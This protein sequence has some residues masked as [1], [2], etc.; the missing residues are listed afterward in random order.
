MRYFELGDV[1]LQSGQVLRAGRL[2]YAAFGRLNAARDNAVLFPTFYTGTHRDNAPLV[3]RG[4]ALDP[5]RW[6]VVVPNLIGNGVSSSPS[7]HAQQARRGFSQGHSARQCPLSEK[8]ARRALGRRATGARVRLVDGRATGLSLRRFV[9]GSGPATLGGV[10]L[11]QDLAAQPGFSRRHQSRTARGPGFCRGPGTRVHRCA[12]SMRSDACT[13]AGPTARPFFAKASTV[14]SATSRPRRC[15]D[16]W[17]ED[18]RAWDA[19]D[20]LA[21]LYAWQRADISDNTL[22]PGRFPARAC[23]DSGADHR[24]ARE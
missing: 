9:S 2:A 10:R 3:A 23:R 4:R 5:E 12:V 21:M 16:G 11:R 1:P 24:H 19:N 22:L 7:N 13:P 8:A 20:L 15:C 14:S 17:A 18:H 6:F